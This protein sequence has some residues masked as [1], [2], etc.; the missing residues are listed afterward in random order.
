MAA[1]DSH[2]DSS[3]VSHAARRSG[4]ADPE[5]F[6]ALVEAELQEVRGEPI[7]LRRQGNEFW[8][9]NVDVDVVGLALSGGGIRSAT[10]NLGL[11][12][13][14]DRVG[15]LPALDYLSTVSGGGYIGGFWTA[16]RRNR[17]GPSGEGGGGRGEPAFPRDP[18]PGGA[19]P[20]PIR[21]LR[22][23]SNF[24]SPRLGLLSADTGRVVVA[25]L[26]A[27][28]PSLL[29]TTSLLV[30]LFAAWAAMALTIGSG[31]L[32]VRV[33]V[34]GGST[35]V[36]LVLMEARL[37]SREESISPRAGRGRRAGLSLVAALVGAGAAAVVGGSLAALAGGGGEDAGAPL[38]A[39]VPDLPTAL[40]GLE[41][42]ASALLWL[43]SLAWLLPA[44]GIVAVRA[45]TARW[46][47]RFWLLQGRTAF[48]RVV[49]RLLL[50]AAIWLVLAGVWW[51]GARLELLR[52]EWLAT[53]GTGVAGLAALA[54]WL[55]KRVAEVLRGGGLGK[56]VVDRIRPRLPTLLAS[57]AVLALA[58]GVVAVV[59]RA[60]DSGWLPALLTGAATF[61]ILTLF[62]FDPNRIGLHSF[63]RGRIARTFLGASN[64]ATQATD[65]RTTEEVEGDDFPM[66]E[67]GGAPLHLVCATANEL[68]PLDPLA[69]LHRGGRSAALSS[70]GFTVDRDWRRWRR[71]GR[72]DSPT[73]AAALTAS[74][75][76]FNPMMGSYSMRLGRAVTF[77]MT[78]LNLRL[79]R[80]MKHP[81]E[82]GESK[83]WWLPGMLFYK[84]LLGVS[85]TDGGDV[86]LSDGGHFE[87]M[88][89][90]E[91][92][93][94]HCRYV[95]TSDCGADPDSSFNDLA[96]LMRRVREDFGVELRLDLS[97]LRP[98][99]D[100]RSRQSV[101][102]GHILYPDGD[103]GT[104]LLF[105]PCLVGGEPEDIA[106]YRR[107]NPLF[108]HESTV[109]QFYDAAQWE[110][111]RRLGQH[112]AESAFEFA[113]GTAPWWPA[114][115]GAA[116]AT[117]R[118]AR[119]GVCRLF[120][121]ARFHW[122]ALPPDH[123][124]R[125]REVAAGTEQLEGTL[126]AAGSRLLVEQVYADTREALSGLDPAS[127]AA[128]PEAA[129]APPPPAAGELEAALPVLRSALRFFEDAHRAL[130]LGGTYTHPEHLGV[131]NLMGRWTRTPLFQLTWPLL[132][133]LHSPDFGRFLDARFGLADLTAGR[134]RVEERSV[135]DLARD[136]GYAAAAWRACRG[137]AEGAYV[138]FSI[139]LRYGR[140]GPE[141][142][143]QV[144]LLRYYRFPAAGDATP[145]AVWSAE[146]LYL[147]PGLWGIGLGGRF[148]QTL[149][150]AEDSP[151]AGHRVV[152]VGLR[153][154][155]GFDLYR[156]EGFTSR[157]DL[158]DFVPDPTQRIRLGSLAGRADGV[159]FM[160]RR[161]L[162]TGERALLEDASAAHLPR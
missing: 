2:H 162:T 30:L 123:Q 109:D 66:A 153:E 78:A 107:S 25:A 88:A 10:F 82:G 19:E 69:S 137:V 159:Q 5:P 120:A 104:M 112:A 72:E 38:S 22:E 89:V 139:P 133:S 45:F 16:W 135:E 93:R 73:L 28:I 21:H 91:L 130:E 9:R 77:L 136:P 40:L 87:N 160:V 116:R 11:L 41:L 44:L 53:Y 118:E 150:A 48:D 95:I 7:A 119:A 144:G 75:A 84:E 8:I 57:A 158:A 29:A 148:L 141:T 37:R 143:V 34:L 14:L 39:Q 15:L 83:N 26:A 67:A 111:Y 65:H 157:S 152:V 4:A 86:H 61:T 103:H 114:D 71:E 79:G 51:A 121:D 106:Q 81:R 60:R 156:Q 122:L 27:M 76:A 97:A 33:A 134:G 132:R 92:I 55:Q 85:R 6:A 24:L 13:G 145:L 161:F 151:V 142:Q 110:S 117:G 31:T 138:A 17:D 54:A 49:A 59:A 50:F 63:Y 155:T 96:T 56:G 42:E 64:P 131:V 68:T 102:V 129:E 99:E 74:A 35:L 100:G 18:S 115:D 113:R 32:A 20:G 90:Y 146:D 128:P 23:F 105:K 126:A 154:G 43:V 149:L 46:M 36:G 125:L 101:V 3:S 98:D 94:R 147:P 62:Y 12:Q 127:A 58:V 70:V 80:W 1:L 124:A 52:V 140:H 108:P 47:R